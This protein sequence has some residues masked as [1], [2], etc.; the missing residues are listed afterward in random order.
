MNEKGFSLVEIMA[1][2]IL[3]SVVLVM[4]TELLLSLKDIYKEG[5]F[6]TT[7]L[8]NQ[9]NIERKI[10]KDLFASSSLSFSSC[11]TNCLKITT[12]Y[13]EKQL[14]VQN[15]EIYYDGKKMDS[16][17]GNKAGN[18]TY[19]TINK[20]IGGKTANIYTIN[21]PVTNKLVEG[22]YGIHLVFQSGTAF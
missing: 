2:F 21:I 18:L 20:T 1:T 14:S 7:L 11:G 5:D 6:K 22:D 4:L 8:I 13:G 16:I 3:I 9:A 15:D 17:N 10:N 19:T 12:P